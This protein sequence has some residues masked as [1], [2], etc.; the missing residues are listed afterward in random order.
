M[1]QLATQL[2]GEKGFALAGFSVGTSWA[3]ECAASGKM[4]DRLR[5]I[6]LFATMSDHTH[7]VH[8]GA[9]LKKESGVGEVPGIM[10]PAGGCCG[11]VVRGA[12]NGMIKSVKKY[13]MKMTFSEEYDHKIGQV[14][15]KEEFA[16]DPFWV[17]SSPVACLLWVLFAR[18]W[19]HMYLKSPKRPPGVHEGRLVP[20]LPRRVGDC[21]RICISNP[22]GPWPCLGF[23]GR[24]FDG[25]GI[26]FSCVVGPCVGLF[27]PCVGTIHESQ[28]LSVPVSWA[29]ATVS[30]EEDDRKRPPGVHED[31]LVPGLPRRDG[32]RGGLPQIVDRAL[33][34]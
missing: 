16:K 23:C 7:K 34:V 15:F 19:A 11:C 26:I 1:D 3:L 27:R 5:G 24:I 21:D 13:D 10:N 18:A 14:V 32:D 8:G 6:L 25:T 33:G 12:L 17:G 4:K 9:K 30:H 22:L 31:R 29:F 28:N 20:G 2:F